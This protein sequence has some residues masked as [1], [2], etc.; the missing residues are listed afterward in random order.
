MQSK[1]K[2]RFHEIKCDYANCYNMAIAYFEKIK[3]R[4]STVG[5]HVHK[6]AAQN[7][8][9]CHIHLKLAL[10]SGEDQNIVHRIPFVSDSHAK[11]VKCLQCGY[12]WIPRTIRIRKPGDE[13]YMQL[14]NECANCRSWR[15]NYS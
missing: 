15:W 10:V 8:K 13:K 12:I 5:E 1:K 6:L 2:P 14:P 9:M 11:S 3:I 4:H 7:V